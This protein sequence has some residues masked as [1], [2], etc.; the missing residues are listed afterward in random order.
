M[1][2][3]LE[4]FLIKWPSIIISDSDISSFFETHS[5]KSSKDLIQRAIYWGWLKRIKRGLY[6]I[7]SPFHTEK[8]SLYEIAQR[9][10][11]PSYISMES[12]LSYHQMIPEAVY[13]TVSACAKRSKEQE[14]PLGLFLFHHVPVQ[15]FYEGVERIQDNQSMFLMASPLKALGDYI[16]AKKKNYSSSKDLQEDLRIEIETLAKQPLE[17]LRLLEHTYPNKRVNNFF[18]LLRKEVFS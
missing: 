12:A 6:V 16:Y 9:I 5:S 17:L 15:H 2:Q 4:Q 3:Q 18:K 13:A 14:T 11:G 1:K 8:P 10:Y 7:G